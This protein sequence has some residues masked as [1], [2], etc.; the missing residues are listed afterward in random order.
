METLDSVIVAAYPKF[1]VPADQIVS[2]PELA[3]SFQQ[4]VRDKLPE[5]QRVDLAT[6]NKRLLNLRRRGQGKG[7]LPRL[8]RGYNGRGPNRPR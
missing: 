7:G 6:M 2:D 1:N 8:E 3:A 5:A 4:V